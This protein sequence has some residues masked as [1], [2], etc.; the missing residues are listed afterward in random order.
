M[1]FGSTGVSSWLDPTLG[2]LSCSVIAVVLSQFLKE[3]SFKA[4]LPICFLVVILLVAMRFGSMAGTLGTIFAAAIFAFYLFEPL[5]S[6]EVKS[7]VGRNNLLWMFLGGL[8]LSELFGHPPDKKPR[9]GGPA[10]L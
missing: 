1:R 9:V 7:Q 6:V 3:T 2:V 5:H 8:I 10:P 4:A